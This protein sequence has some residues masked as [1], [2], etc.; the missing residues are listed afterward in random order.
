[1]SLAHIEHWLFFETLL[2]S[3]GT[4]FLSAAAWLGSMQVSSQRTEPLLPEPPQ[5]ESTR[6]VERGSYTEDRQCR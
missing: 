3:K 4:G 6:Q 5:V 1:M 2:R